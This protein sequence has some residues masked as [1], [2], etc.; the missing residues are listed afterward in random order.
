M[1]GQNDGAA[2][3]EPSSAGGPATDFSDHPVRYDSVLRFCGARGQ[4][5]P[6]PPLLIE[7]LQIFGEFCV[8]RGCLWVSATYLLATSLPSLSTVISFAFSGTAV[9]VTRPP[10]QRT[11][12]FAGFSG[13]A[14]TWVRLSC[15]QYPEPACSSRAGP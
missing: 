14:I 8:F 9:V 5:V 7:A 6:A 2:A 13:V 1:V 15:D 3:L 11:Q 4:A 12:S 10:G